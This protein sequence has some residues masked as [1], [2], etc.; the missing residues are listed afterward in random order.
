MENLKPLDKRNV[1]RLEALPSP[2][3]MIVSFLKKT[4]MEHSE[5]KLWATNYQYP[6]V[7]DDIVAKIR[8]LLTR[9]D[10]YLARKAQG[11]QS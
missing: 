8:P 11:S 2:Y 10:K 5:A 3:H 7:A 1:E 6:Q 9:R 4:G